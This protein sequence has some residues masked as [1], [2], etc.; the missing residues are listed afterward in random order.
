MKKYAL[1]ITHSTNDPDRSNG[2][3][4]LAASLVSLGADV[5][6]FLNFQ[7]VLLAKAG[8]A[9]TIEGRN[10]TPVRELFPMILEAGVPIYACSAGAATY[11]LTE[12]ELVPNARIA[13]L[14]TLAFEMDDRETMTL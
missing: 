8:V 3:V 11:G 13:T 9:D 10:F 4:A 2:A 7:G 12:A 1:V 14:P 6:I 5:I